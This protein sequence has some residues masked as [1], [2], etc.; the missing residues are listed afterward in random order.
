M[1]I[2]TYPG[3]KNGSGTYQQIINQI[4]KHDL[5]VELF[6]GS[7]A[8]YKN[9]LPAANSLLCDIDGSVIPYLKSISSPGTIVLNCDTVQGINIFVSLLNVL[10]TAGTA[11]FCYLDPPYPFEARKSQNQLYNY[12]MDNSGHIALLN[13]M[14]PAI[15]PYAISTYD[16]ELYSGFLG[17]HRKIKFN[18]TT[19]RGSAVETLYMNYPIPSELHDYRY[20]GNTFREREAI[21]R[22]ISNTAG[23]INSWSSI[24]KNALLQQLQF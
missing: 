10:H 21:Q 19:R 5:Y 15:F 7:A 18:S 1:N 3:G 6:A 4:P 14:V 2:T 12:E 9:K 20:I 16:N 23:K 24:E 17:H 8:I 22:S 11:V 13:G